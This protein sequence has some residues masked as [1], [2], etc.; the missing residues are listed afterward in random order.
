MEGIALIETGLKPRAGTSPQPA[1]THPRPCLRPQP[2]LHAAPL[3]LGPAPSTWETVCPGSSAHW[4]PA[5]PSAVTAPARPSV[6]TSYIPTL[7]PRG[8]LPTEALSLTP[9]FHQRTRGCPP[10]LSTAL[11]F[12]STT[13]PV[14]SPLPAAQT[15]TW[16]VMEKPRPYSGPRP[17][18]HPWAVE[19]GWL[20]AAGSLALQDS[21]CASGQELQAGGSATPH[22]GVHERALPACESPPHAHAESTAGDR[23]GVSFSRPGIWIQRFVLSYTR[24]HNN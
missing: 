16:G 18:G 9:K 1:R 10:F 14:S 15:H 7:S 2:S 3:S 13:G 5:A 8:C 23:A 20:A 19:P 21:L 22:R 6:V 11:R 24:A 17:K 4:A 12:T